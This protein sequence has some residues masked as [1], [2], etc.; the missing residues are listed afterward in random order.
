VDAELAG[1][2]AGLIG[3]AAVQ[4]ARPF[5]PFGLGFG[6]GPCSSWSTMRSPPETHRRGYE[7]M[8]TGTVVILGLALMMFPDNLFG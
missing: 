7:Q 1:P 5:L 8:I 4:I 3:V 6:A 2:I